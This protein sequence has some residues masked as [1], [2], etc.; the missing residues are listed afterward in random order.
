M[1]SKFVSRRYRSLSLDL[2]LKRLFALKNNNKASFCHIESL[3]KKLV[4]SP[5]KRYL[6]VGAND[7]I[8]QSNTF[9]LEKTLGWSGL[10][11]DANPIELEK[12]KLLRSY[13]NSF[14]LNICTEHDTGYSKIYL[15]GLMSIVTVD[16]QLRNIQ[17]QV[18]Q[19]Q[20]LYSENN[21]WTIRV[22]SRRIDTIAN[23]VNV[24]VID[25]ASIDVEGAEISLLNGW[26][27]TKLSISLLLVESTD[28]AAVTSLLH[29]KSMIYVISR[30][31]D[32]LFASQA[33]LDSNP[34]LPS[35]ALRWSRQ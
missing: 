31:H 29:A 9:W 28:L 3:L 18:N 32:H 5:Q 26:D 15:A 17:T 27:K 7:G 2:F 12:A 22:S 13:R 35:Y 11:I 6:E 24:S 25:F 33:F 20:Q 10:L 14:F 30:G 16:G 4:F 23:C 19:A 8:T 1:L 21:T 34:Y